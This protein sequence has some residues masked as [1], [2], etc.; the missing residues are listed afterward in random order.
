MIEK[1]AIAKI[2]SNRPG[3]FVNEH[4]AGR[5][6]T[7]QLNTHR[8][9]YLHVQE[10]RVCH[11]MG[12]VCNGLACKGDCVFSAGSA[13]SGLLPAASLCV[14]GHATLEGGSI[15]VMGAPGTQSREFSIGFNALDEEIR[16]QRQTLARK[17]GTTARYTHV[18][19]GYIPRQ[20]DIGNDGWFVECE[21]ASDTLQAI[22]SAVS[23]GTLRAMTL[24]LALR[25]VYSD[26]WSRP[27]ALTDWFLRPSPKDN[28]IDAPQMAHGDITR[29]SFD[30]ASVALRRPPEEDPEQNEFQDT[31]PE[32]MAA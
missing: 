24:G 19:L 26:D 3:S 20:S 23:S 18:T 29:L 10:L 1:N 14:R 11:E 15:S 12:L 17:Q 7:Y 2:R 13:R 9:M 22:S 30:L 27:S 32:M 25:G 21:L 31:S 8:T 5:E 28:R 4:F 16:A 6:Q